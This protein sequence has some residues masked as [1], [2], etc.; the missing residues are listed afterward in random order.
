MLI[1]IVIQIVIV[2]IRIVIIVIRVIGTARLGLE[3]V[4]WMSIWAEPLLQMSFFFECGIWGLRFR[5]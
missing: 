5:I 1:T 3:L 2:E 4:L